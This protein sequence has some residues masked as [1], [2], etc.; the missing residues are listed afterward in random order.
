MKTIAVA[1]TVVVSLAGLAAANPVA[2]PQGFGWWNRR[3]TTF[4]T[5]TVTVPAPSDAP[6]AGN[7]KPPVDNGTPAGNPKPSE[8]PKPGGN[9][10]SVGGKGASF[11][12]Y[13]T[14]TYAVIAT[15]DQVINGTV[16]TPGEPGAIGYYNYGINS[17][18]EVLCYVSTSNPDAEGHRC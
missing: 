6:D 16:A 7:S 17:D 3:P 2:E 8:T 10:G 4:T 11:P 15:P 9:G 18:L 13:F 5:V 12:F 1:A 14:S